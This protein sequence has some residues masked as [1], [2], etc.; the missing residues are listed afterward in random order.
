MRTTGFIED[1]SRVRHGGRSHVSMRLRCVR[2]GTAGLEEASAAFRCGPCG[3]TFAIADGIPRF[4]DTEAHAESF[5]FQWKTFA[6][7]QLDSAHGSS[8]SRSTFVEKTGW[9]LEDLRGRQVL[10]A[11]C[12]MGRFAEVAADAGAE[13]HGVDLSL[14]IDAARQN[15]GH[16]PSIHLYQAD[17]MNLPFV[18]DTFDFIYSI[19]VL[20]H[21][22]NPRRAFLGLTRL[23]R[24]GG[25][26]AIWVYSRK[27]R[28]SI[29]SELLRMVT[30]RLPK[31]WLL[32]ACRIAIP[33]Y[34]L[35]R[36][37][38]AGHLSRALL[39]TSLEPDPTW[40]WLDTFDWYSPRYQSKH[41]Y[42]EVE[43]WFQEAGIAEVHRGP[44]PITVAGRKPATV[45]GAVRPLTQG[46]TA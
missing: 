13:V 5:G 42:A 46:V 3:A 2:C 38:L 33:L 27:L 30:P 25:V 39:L 28:L 18:D 24:P 37:P 26:I 29:G 1:E 15:L 6:T 44:F 40:R 45:S 19:G 11:G 31:P 22:P 21:T 14:A 43:G 36:V 20:H 12:G 16:R 7:V 34:W 35:H 9:R 17:L 4:V 23:L 41:S 32:K 10:D 8:I